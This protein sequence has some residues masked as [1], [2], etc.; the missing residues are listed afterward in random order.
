M[1][2]LARTPASGVTSGLRLDAPVSHV[3][4]INLNVTAI[5]GCEVT[6]PWGIPGCDRVVVSRL[7]S[8]GVYSGQEMR[9]TGRQSALHWPVERLSSWDVE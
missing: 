5:R 9:R 7:T 1:I 2:E 3:A 4:R 6:Q 8:R